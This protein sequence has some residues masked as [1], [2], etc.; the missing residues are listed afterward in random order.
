MRTTEQYF[1]S[2][3][4]KNLLQKNIKKSVSELQKMFPHRSYR[5]IEGKK[6]EFQKSMGIKGKPVTFK[7][8]QQAKPWTTKEEKILMDHFYEDID[9]LMERL[10]GRTWGSI[11]KKRITINK[12]IEKKDMKYGQPI[13]PN[14]TVLQANMVKVTDNET[15]CIITSKRP[16]TEADLIEMFGIDTNIWQASKWW[17]EAKDITTYRGV[18]STNF[19]SRI[20]FQRKV[21]NINFDLVRAELKNILKQEKAID[22]KQYK[23]YKFQKAD[24][25]LEVNI[26]DLHLG[27][28]CWEGEVMVNWDHKIAYDMV[29]NAVKDLMSKATLFGFDKILLPFGNDFFHFNDS[30]QTTKKGTPMSLDTRWPKIYVAGQRL[31][32]EII[33]YLLQFAP[34]DVVSIISNHDE[35]LMMTTTEALKTIYRNNPNVTVDK[36]WPT[37]V[38]RKYYKYHNNV[39]GFTHGSEEKL[40]DLAK[41]MP[42]ELRNI[43]D[44][45]TDKIWWECQHTEFH[46]AHKHHQKGI[47]TRTMEDDKGVIIRYMQAVCPED[48]WTFRKGFVGSKKGIQ[49]FIYNSQTGLVSFVNSNIEY[50]PEHSQDTIN[51]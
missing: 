25:L 37:F 21:G 38:S 2:L 3:A 7:N 10:P 28:L 45:E 29:I 17:V 11:K 13:K 35:T 4:E 26:A 23:P 40:Q 14:E 20:T 41:I 19:L 31:I 44:K 33:D 39:I 43:K 34:V 48:D 42:L 49:G 51:Q 8:I 1:W 15:N 16:L 5:A 6:D 30:Q 12:K 9:K 46:I 18:Q 24:N 50:K 22:F 27:K 32:Q 36:D 47:E